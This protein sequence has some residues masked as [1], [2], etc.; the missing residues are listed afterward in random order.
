MIEEEKHIVYHSNSPSTRS[1]HRPTRDLRTHP[2]ATCQNPR[3]AT[4]ALWIFRFERS[5]CRA[6]RR[7]KIWPQPEIQ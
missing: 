2:L 7:A 3:L 5:T 6:K 4:E 1:T